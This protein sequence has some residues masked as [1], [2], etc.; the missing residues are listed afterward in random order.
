M[1]CEQIFKSVSRFG[2][3]SSRGKSSA[4]VRAWVTTCDRV[5]TCDPR[6][7]ARH[8]DRRRLSRS[9]F[10]R[11]N[12][13]TSPRIP[14]GRGT[15]ARTG[16]MTPGSARSSSSSFAAT[17]IAS[18]LLSVLLSSSV[19]TSAGTATLGR[20]PLFHTKLILPCWLFVYV[21]ISGD[22]LLSFVFVYLL[23][24]LYFSF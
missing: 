24:F 7:A 12:I 10:A 11:W 22:Q 15:T 20:W 14:S 13:I 2:Q 18:V 5:S 3:Q 23:V 1:C 4:V 8:D 16:E 19:H 17:A 6:V 21:Y 9:E